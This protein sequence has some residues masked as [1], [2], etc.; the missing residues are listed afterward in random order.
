LIFQENNY[1]YFKAIF[2]HIVANV[3]A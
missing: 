1:N 3:Q 2:D